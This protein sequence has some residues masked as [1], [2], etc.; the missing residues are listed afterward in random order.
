MALQLAIHDF[1]RNELQNTRMHNL[2]TAPGSPNEGLYYW[3]TALDQMGIWN[4]TAW[5]YLGSGSGTVT[6]V[7]L[8]MPGIFSVS[9]SPVTTNGTLTANLAT[10]TANTFFSGPGSAGPSVPTFRTM[11]Q[12]DLPSSVPISYWAAATANVSMGTSYKITNL[13]DPTNPQDAATK[14]YVDGVAQGLDI[15]YSCKAATTANIT[16]S[17][18]QTVD[19]VAL[20]A[21]D[22]CLVKNQTTVANNGMYVVNAGAWTRTLDFDAWAELPG[23]FTFIEQG[24]VNAESGWVCTSDGGGTLGTTDI[25]FVQFSGAGQITAGNGLTK[26]GNTISVLLDTNPGLSISGTGI[27]VSLA[28][29]SGLTTAGGLAIVSDTVTAGTLALTLTANGAGT[30]YNTTSFTEATEALTL[31]STVV[32]AAGAI[33]LTTNA[34]GVN[35][36][37]STIEINTNALRVKAAGINHNHIASSSLNTTLTGGSGTT[38][39]VAGYTFISGTTVA[40]K[41]LQNAVSLATG[42]FSVAVTHNLNNKDVMVMVRDATD[43]LIG[44]DWQANTVNQVTISGNN[45]TGGAISSNVVVIG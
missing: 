20:V 22:R 41:Y 3:D 40:R 27:R 21:L 2:A 26:S 15:K 31:A 25:T 13:L 23:G 32:Q 39:G 28:A 34:L 8:S 7:A 12:A 35:V 9:G 33:N 37:N 14:A 36:D 42:A 43:N 24:T 44:V 38:L 6:S 1:N 29:T 45:N 16:L 5:V 19:G 30:K 10:Q 17:G 11:V 4:G 18:T